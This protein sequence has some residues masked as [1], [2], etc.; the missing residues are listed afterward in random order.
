MIRIC[1]NIYCGDE[2]DARK[3]IGLS[4]WV[5]LHCCKDPFHKELVGYRGNLNSSHPNYSYIIKGNRMAL[6]LVDMDFY[7]PNYLEFNYN[8]FTTAFSFLDNNSSDKKILI[9]C[10]QGESRGPS[11]TMLYLKHVG[12]FK[13]DSYLSAKIKFY[14]MYPK[15]NPKRNIITNIEVLWERF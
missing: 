9:H 7:S 13:E 4:D 1:S 2:I 8:M 11:L 6:N 15:F 3:V 5:I 14:Q 10:N 12:Y